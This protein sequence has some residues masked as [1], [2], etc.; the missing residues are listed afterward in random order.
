MLM[1]LVDHTATRVMKSHSVIKSIM[2]S[3]YTGRMVRRG[4][5]AMVDDCLS[6]GGG[7]GAGMPKELDGPATPT[8]D[9]A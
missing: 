5:L 8:A 9:I 1:T 3:T 6:M 2:L 4:R 7:T